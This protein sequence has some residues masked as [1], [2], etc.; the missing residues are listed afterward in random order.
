MAQQPCKKP[1]RCEEVVECN[2]PEEKNSFPYVGSLIRW[3]GAKCYTYNQLLAN[4]FGALVEI[5]NAIKEYSEAKTPAVSGILSYRAEGYDDLDD[6]ESTS[7]EFF[8]STFEYE[9]VG[10]GASYLQPALSTVGTI[11]D[12][13][14]KVIVKVFD[15]TAGEQIGEDLALSIVAVQANFHNLG[16]VIATIGLGHKV[17]IQI[18]FDADPGDDMEAFPI[19]VFIVVKPKALNINS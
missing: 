19:D 13:S 2:C 14:D 11:Y 9:V 1:T 10:I 6:G 4:I 5:K 16:N 15:F 17:G 18:E 12:A 7:V 8:T 3:V